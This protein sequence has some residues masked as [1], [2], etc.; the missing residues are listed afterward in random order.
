LNNHPK[1]LTKSRVS[2]ASSSSQLSFLNV[3]QG[4]LFPEDIV[5][6]LKNEEKNI[7]NFKDKIEREKLKVENDFSVIRT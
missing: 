1:G 5:F 2:V 7:N 6:L 4:E 3:D